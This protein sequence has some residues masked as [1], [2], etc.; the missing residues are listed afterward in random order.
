MVRRSGGR[1]HH[2]AKLAHSRRPQKALPSLGIVLA[3]QEPSHPLLPARRHDC[4]QRCWT[5]ES[6][7]RL[8]P[9][10][11]CSTSVRS[12]T[13]RHQRLRQRQK[14]TL[15]HEAPGL[16]GGGGED[17]GK[18]GGGGRTRVPRP[19]P[20]LRCEGEKK[21]NTKKKIIRSPL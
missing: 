10:A 11:R 3:C 20:D 14:L 6:F 7:P 12:S 5:A 16:G 4:F 21:L 1:R 9:Q 15:R 19:Q 8:S 13:C 18:G 17:G 2:P